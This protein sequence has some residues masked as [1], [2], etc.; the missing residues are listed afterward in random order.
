[1][2]PGWLSITLIAAAL[3]ALAL[4]A[5]A[6]PAELTTP[7]G[8]VGLR[9]AGKWLWSYSARDDNTLNPGQDEFNTSLADLQVTG[10]VGEHV[11][12]H[13]EF[14]GTY[15]SDVNAGGFNGP[16]SP[17][18]TG[19][20]GV[21]Q[22]YI[23][24][25]EVVPFT[26]LKIGTFIPPVGNYMPRQVWDLDLINYPLVYNASM[27]NTGLFQ[28]QVVNL[29]SGMWQQTG[30][31]LNVAL[32][33]M[34]SFDVGM[35]NGRMP[36]GQANW[37]ENV[38]KA[39][40]VAA[41]FQPVKPFSVSLAYWGEEFQQAY[42]GVTRNTKR[43]LNIWYVYCA[44]D[45]DLLEVTLDYAQGS[46]PRFTIDTA[47][48]F[49]DLRWEAW[50]FTVGYWLRPD[51]EVL[52][53]YEQI[54]PNTKDSVSIPSSRYDESEWLTLGMNYRLNERLEVSLNYI[55]KKEEG[56]EVD[57]GDPGQDPNLPGFNPKYSVQEN[58]QLLIQVQVWQ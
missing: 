2:K 17:G 54:D 55:F 35:Y 7:S 21:R 4:P 38:A 50:Q 6:A 49:Q 41:T 31:S 8:N 18:E 30:F 1:M 57:E 11:R 24:F 51:L 53:R 52:A 10:F 16:S 48:E 44:Y 15:N 47:G 28:N 20:F 45:S 27:M 19:V 34:V 46:I 22:A 42:P 43:D 9:Y 26:K 14:A 25:E 13:F 39:T 32:P 36:N 3:A 33:Y 56:L 29:D 5:A 40:S 12:Y 37:N 58:D 23:A